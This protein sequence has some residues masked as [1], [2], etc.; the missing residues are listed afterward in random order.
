MSLELPNG[1][2]GLHPYQPVPD[3]DDRNVFDG[4]SAFSGP[5]VAAFS[6]LLSKQI[7]KVSKPSANSNSTATGVG[8]AETIHNVRQSKIIHTG[9]PLDLTIEGEGYFIL[10][11][12]RQNIYTRSGAFTV[13]ANS[14]LVDPVTGY[15]LQRIGP[16]GE[17]D[18][19]QVPGDRNI[20]I[21]YRAVMP[22]KGT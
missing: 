5:G 2:G 18:G 16:A 4:D 3:I 17:G 14:K 8:T 7:E 21:P 10:S 11:D 19:F 22:A 12:G 13:D 1:I 20:R 15:A 6:E 9:N